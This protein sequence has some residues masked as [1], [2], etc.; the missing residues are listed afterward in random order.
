MNFVSKWHF[1]VISILFTIMAPVCRADTAYRF[2]KEIAVSGDEGWDYLSMDEAA[3]CLY[4]TNGSK[5]VVINL[6]TE[7]VAGE[8]RDTFGVHGFAIARDLGLGFSSNG[9]ESKASIVDLKTLKTLSKVDTGENPDAIVYNQGEVYTFNGKGHSVTVFDAKS[10]KGV[11]TSPLSGKPE[12]AVTDGVHLY[13]NI[14]DKNEVAVIDAKTHSVVNSWAIAPGAEAT[15]LAIDLLHHR[16]FIGCHNKTMVMMDSMNGKVVATVPIGQGVDATVFDPATQL[17]FCSNG[18]GT[19]TI[20]RE[21]SPE[22][23][24][25]E[26][27]LSTERGART[28]ALDSTTHKIYLASAQ[29]EP[30]PEQIPGTPRQRPKMI[31]GSFKIL[32][33]GTCGN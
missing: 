33:Y 6:D 29:F 23:L 25:P 31:P 28:M 7:V 16:L 13:C 10:G 14:E 12:F 22:K 2:L 15:G 21:E 18:E 17:V 27:V 30:V 4:V 32:V 5:V 9:K 19:V 20:A 26:Q 8:I 1:L 24:T 3:R 11:A